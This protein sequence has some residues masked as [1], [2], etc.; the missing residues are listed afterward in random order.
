M[1]VCVCV[2]PRSLV[3]PVSALL[4]AGLCQ[5]VGAAAEEE[6]TLTRS[7]V[8]FGPQ[9][10]FTLTTT[11]ENILAA[12]SCTVSREDHLSERQLK[13]SPGPGALC[14]AHSLC[15]KSV[16]GKKKKS[17]IVLG[18]KKKKLVTITNVAL[19]HKRS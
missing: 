16:D 13:H 10:W 19:I 15:Y 3:S 9:S 2:V 6:D 4:A 18:K 17:N 11:C 14:V 5:G 8:A 1:C 7:S 12:C